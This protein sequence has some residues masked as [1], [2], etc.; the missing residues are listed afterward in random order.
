M[1]TLAAAADG[2]AA[3]R[4]AATVTEM[5]PA[6]VAF[7]TATRREQ[8]RAK[9]KKSAKVAKVHGCML[10]GSVRCGFVTAHHRPWDRDDRRK[11]VPAVGPVRQESCRQ[12]RREVDRS[13]GS[14]AADDEYASWER[15]SN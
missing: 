7:V 8:A 15:G 12:F 1:A 14:D 4:L 3:S 10:L 6:M 5:R 9:G 2:S 11:R 13:P